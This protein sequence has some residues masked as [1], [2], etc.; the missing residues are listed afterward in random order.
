MNLDLNIAISNLIL[1]F[2]FTKT[3]TT[4]LRQPEPGITAL[5]KQPRIAL[6]KRV[7][8]KR[9]TAPGKLVKTQ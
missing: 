4:A 2:S 8:T 9:T 3:G 1:Y 5:T 6:V 7:K